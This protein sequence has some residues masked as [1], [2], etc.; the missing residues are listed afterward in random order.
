MRLYRKASFSVFV[1]EHEKTALGYPLQFTADL[2]GNIFLLYSSGNIKKI[3]RGADAQS[4]SLTKLS[5]SLAKGKAIPC[6]ISSGGDDCL[7]V[8]FCNIEAMSRNII[9]LNSAL[10]MVDSFDV[11]FDGSHASTR[12][13]LALS[14]HE[15]VLPSLSKLPDDTTNLKKNALLDAFDSQGRHLFSFG[16][17]PTTED[18]DLQDLL[19]QGTFAAD[20]KKHVYFSF[21]Y[22]Y[23]IL[24]FDSHGALLQSIH[25]EM[26]FPV[27]E[28]MVKKT[29]KKEDKNLTLTLGVQRISKSLAVGAHYI[30]NLVSL[31][32][33]ELAFPF[34]SGLDIYSSQGNYLETLELEA[35][36]TNIH[37]GRH[38][39]LY[40]LYQ[41]LPFY[42]HPTELI[43]YELR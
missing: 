3:G 32:V 38:E 13:V 6:G 35:P 20:P 10:T 9:R 25:R 23:K 40:I 37:C 41:D 29:F 15:V 8:L 22:P 33:E 4:I 1:D 21:D 43:Q 34:G 42:H 30:F 7:L 2:E 11:P 14:P 39:N 5:K 36:A 26:T 28:P 24:K 17:A 12:G 27:R 31:N 19:R 18:L 16:Q